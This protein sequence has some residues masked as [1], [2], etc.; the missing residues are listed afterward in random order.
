MTKEELIK[1]LSEC[2]IKKKDI[3]IR[4]GMPK[5]SLSG[6]MGGTK[7]IPE[8]WFVLLQGIVENK[9]NSDDAALINFASE[10][11]INNAF[12]QI[13]EEKVAHQI[14]PEIT[15]KPEKI[16]LPKAKGIMMGSDYL[17]ALPK[18]TF[19]NLLIEF[20]S[21]VEDLPPIKQV[22]DKLYELILK[23]QDANLNARQSEAIRDRC[24]Y[25]LKGQ[26]SGQKAKN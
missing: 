20:N 10:V 8:K 22:E 11:S 14:E 18:T 5:N 9:P 21:L 7:P 1:G 26:Y 24:I 2:G 16:V 13:E 19:Q 15:P 3:E 4:L 12:K 23:S 17:A 25:Y 6:M